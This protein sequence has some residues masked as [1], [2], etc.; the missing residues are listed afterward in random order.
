MTLIF[1]IRIIH[2]TNFD[3]RNG[4]IF[5][6]SIHF[7]VATN[8]NLL[9]KTFISST[10]PPFHKS[11]TRTSTY[12]LNISVCWL[13]FFVF[14]RWCRKFETMVKFI[15][16]L[17]GISTIEKHNL[18]NNQ[19]AMLLLFLLEIS[20]RV[21]NRNEIKSNKKRNEKQNFKNTNCSTVSDS[22][23]SL[24]HLS[25]FKCTFQ[26]WI[27]NGSTFFLQNINSTGI[28]EYTHTPKLTT[29]NELRRENV[30][31]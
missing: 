10:N 11:H 12:Q 14:F 9:M 26:N 2:H 15:A 4:S 8:L 16:Q 29:R 20:F 19:S 24:N 1:C 31:I 5:G 23:P 25:K 22:I 28:F 21:V 13:R 7:R 3:N 27:E 30:K 17:L 18:M 6:R